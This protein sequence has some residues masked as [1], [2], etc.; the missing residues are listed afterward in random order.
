M[1]TIFSICCRAPTII[2]PLAALAQIAIAIYTF[3]DN[4]TGLDISCSIFTFISGLI[5]GYMGGLVLAD[6]YDFNLLVAGVTSFAM[7]I[8]VLVIDHLQINFIRDLRLIAAFSFVCIYITL[9]VTG[10]GF[11]VGTRQH[12]KPQKLQLINQYEPV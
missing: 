6:L 9:A 12:R 2:M 8:V 4:G 3:K 11:A 10:L 5:H 7:N 1:E